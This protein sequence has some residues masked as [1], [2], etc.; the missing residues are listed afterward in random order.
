MTIRKM[1]LTGRFVDNHKNY[2]LY[3]QEV[4]SSPLSA[5]TIK[6]LRF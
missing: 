5:D 6:R 3:A 4:T 1:S 2:Y